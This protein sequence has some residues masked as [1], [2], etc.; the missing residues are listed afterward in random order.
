MNS[1][2]ITIK[3]A[4]ELTGKS[5]STIRRNITNLASVINKKA[6]KSIVIKEKRIFKIDYSYLVKNYSMTSQNET[7]TS[8]EKTAVSD[9][10]RDLR[11]TIKMYSIMLGEKDK[12]IEYL[13]N[14]LKEYKEDKTFLKEMNKSLTIA[15]NNS[16][17]L[18]GAEKDIL[19][20][21]KSSD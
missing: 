12:Q 15:L 4:C 9:E 3:E 16:Q 19:F 7:T 20:L 11:E 21:N 17:T 8:Q 10:I 18:L 6:G 2:Y 14:E 13:N 5:E 1:H